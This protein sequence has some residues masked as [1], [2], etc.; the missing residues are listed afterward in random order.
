[1]NTLT[2][3]PELT[4]EQL[5]YALLQRAGVG[6]FD[7]ARL[8][9]EFQHCSGAPEARLDMNH[10]LR[11]IQ[12]GSSGIS[13]E[14]CVPDVGEAIGQ[15]L[16]SKTHRRE[17][18]RSELQYYTRS[19]QRH[20]P[21]WEKRSIQGISTEECQK[22]LEASFPNLHSRRK[23]RTI[24]HGFFAFCHKR[25]WIL[26][27]PAAFPD[28]PPPP[29]RRIVPLSL[30]QA[31]ELL[32]CCMQETFRNCAAAVGLM[33]WAGVRPMEVERLRWENIKLEERVIVL[34]PQHTKTG[35]ARCATIQPALAW[36]L[37][38]HERESGSLCPRNWKRRWRQLHQA[39]GL[40]PWVPDILRHSFASYHIACFRNFERLQYEMGHR[41][42]QL[43]RFRYLA[44][45]DISPEQ[46]TDFWSSNYWKK[47]LSQVSGSLRSQVSAHFVG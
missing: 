39:A 4:D 25:G 1:M 28:V 42:L 34:H 30:P 2:S 12:R 33:L 23:A 24:L 41:S 43:L 29:E 35:G 37:R 38:L 45:G 18:T 27:N 20:N 47:Q 44:T 21:D 5:A 19:F 36:W 22:M 32:R 16:T 7:V 17:R 11:V 10:C 26:E 40:T 15:F 14:S 31:G 3:Y 9:L 13:P 8:V 46:A 6:L